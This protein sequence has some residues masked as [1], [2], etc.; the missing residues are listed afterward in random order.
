MK[1]FL[2]ILG[3]ISLG[4]GIIGIFLPV[5]P[6]TP[7]VL[8][9][10]YLF[11][12]S[13]ERFHKYLLHHKLFGTIIRDFNEKKVIRRKNKIVALTSMWIVLL[14]SVIFFMPFWWAKLIVILIGIGT[15]IYLITFPEEDKR[16]REKE[17]R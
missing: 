17:K 16:Q 8:L 3:F 14:S 11:G 13:S 10:A 4:L 5:L 6:T 15:T 2:M 9:S 12:K 1:F 7:F